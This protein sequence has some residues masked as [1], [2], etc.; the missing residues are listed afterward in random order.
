MYKDFEKRRLYIQAKK[1]EERILQKKG[2]QETSHLDFG[3]EFFIMVMDTNMVTNTVTLGRVSNFVSLVYTGNFNGIIGYGRG[4]GKDAEISLLKAIDN[5]KQNLI[6]ID[7]DIFNT[8]PTFQS[9][10]FNNVRMRMWP[11]K[12]LNS[13]GSLTL[14]SMIQIAGINNCM[15]RQIYGC[16]KPLTMLYCFFM[17]VTQNVTPRV[18]AEKMGIKENE[19]IFGSTEKMKRYPKLFY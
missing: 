16:N 1:Q 14:G 10:R 12:E 15:F 6:A 11:R 9:S 8:M 19:T 7:L 3:G 4:R 18:L 2:L 17:L 5:C 13:W